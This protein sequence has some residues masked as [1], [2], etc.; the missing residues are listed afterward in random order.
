MRCVVAALVGTALLGVD[1]TSSFPNPTPQGNS[2]GPCAD[3]VAAV[4]TQGDGTTPGSCM[5]CDPTTNKCA[6]KCQPL[7]D[8]LYKACDG[9]YTP[10]DYTFDPA[11]VI[12]GYW[13]DCKNQI[14]IA[15]Q[16]CGCNFAV[17]SGVSVW[18]LL[19]FTLAVLLV[20]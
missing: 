10:P 4:N 9:V 14:R 8:T 1:A 11:G 16:R 13:N 12:S 18:P 6:P 17:T 2:W 15:V 19:L 5:S 7:I 20:G 3:A